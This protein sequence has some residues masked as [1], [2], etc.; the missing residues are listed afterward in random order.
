MTYMKFWW[1]LLMIGLGTT[2][3]HSQPLKNW[4]CSCFLFNHR[5][6][7]PP[8]TNYF[9]VVVLVLF[10]SSIVICLSKVLGFTRLHLMR[11]LGSLLYLIKFSR[12]L[13]SLY[14]MTL[15]ATTKYDLVIDRGISAASYGMILVDAI[16]GI[17]GP[18]TQSLEG[19]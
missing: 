8:K 18:R 14:F 1:S 5:Y 19:L 6:C 16:N 15:L 17:V 7:F 10:I 9:D 3:I 12:L 13:T 4:Y 11:M 2:N